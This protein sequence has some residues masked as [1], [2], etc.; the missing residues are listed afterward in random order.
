MCIFVCQKSRLRVRIIQIFFKH[1][2]SPPPPALYKCMF[3]FEM[4]KFKV[5]VTHGYV[6][7]SHFESAVGVLVNHQVKR[8]VPLLQKNNLAI[9]V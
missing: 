9:Q 6:T 3:V 2:N 5:L 1:R 8:P 7:H 4:P